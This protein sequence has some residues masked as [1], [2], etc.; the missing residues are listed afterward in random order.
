MKKT[1]IFLL[2]A[3]IIVSC[4]KSNYKVT[5]GYTQGTTYRII[6][7]SENNYDNKIRELLKEF[8][9][10]LSN[11]N[12]SS[13]ITHINNNVPNVELNKIFVTFYNKSKYSYKKTNGFFDIT[14]GPIVKAWGFGAKEEYNCDSTT[15]DSLLQYVG[16]NKIKI[17]NN[18]LI[19]EN[20]NIFINSNAIAQGQSV[21]FIAEF[22]D[23]QN[24]NNYLIEIGGE[25]RTKGLNNE[26]MTWRIGIDKPVE[27]LEHRELQ[28]IVSLDNK[29]LA[30]SGNYRKFVIHE[31]KKYSHSI[32]PKTGYPVKD[33]ILSAT[34]VTTECSIAD[35]YATACMVMGFDLAKEF[36][37]KHED[38]EAYFIYSGKNGKFETYA[39]EGFKKFVVEK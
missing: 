38:V 11:Y 37:A 20:P 1:S 8:D 25:L 15:I 5:E 30:T 32:N 6:Y 10:V 28:A 34:I 17:E 18:R 13:M 14:V 4:N 21:D 23:S 7:E 33:K 19:K 3:L 29:S 31:G 39:T 35:A 26:S 16:M 12:D 36:V 9:F 27:G 24:I 22:F 2:F